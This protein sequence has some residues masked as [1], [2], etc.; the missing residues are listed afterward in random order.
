MKA[1]ADFFR[2]RAGISPQRGSEQSTY[3][4]HPAPGGTPNV[5]SSWGTLP[6]EQIGGSSSSHAPPPGSSMGALGPGAGDVYSSG[7]PTSS[8]VGIGPP[9]GAGQQAPPFG[10]S[11]GMPVQQGAHLDVAPQPTAEPMNGFASFERTGVGGGGSLG[12]PDRRGMDASNTGPSGQQPV[13]DSAYYA[14]FNQTAPQSGGGARMMDFQAQSSP[15]LSKE[16]AGSDAISSSHDGKVP[17]EAEVDRI[18]ADLPDSEIDGVTLLSTIEQAV[19]NSLEQGN[20]DRVEKLSAMSHRLSNAMKSATERAVSAFDQGSQVAAAAATGD[21]M[22]EAF[23]GGQPPGAPS[24]PLT[25]GDELAFAD[26]KA[27]KSRKK[28]PKKKKKKRG[29]SV[30]STAEAF[31]ND[32]PQPTGASEPPPAAAPEPSSSEFP[33]NFFDIA[34]DAGTIGEPQPEEENRFPGPGSSKAMSTKSKSDSD[35]GGGGGAVTSDMEFQV[36]DEKGS[37]R[38]VNTEVGGDGAAQADPNNFR[39]CSSGSEN[40]FA[41]HR[42]ERGRHE[43]NFSLRGVGRGA[44]N[45]SKG[46]TEA[47]DDADEKTIANLIDRMMDG[48]T[49]AVRMPVPAPRGAFG[50]KLSSKGDAAIAGSAGVGTVPPSADVESAAAPSDAGSGAKS[51]PFDAGVQSATGQAGQTIVDPAVNESRASSLAGPAATNTTPGSALT[52]GELGAS[53]GAATS[54]AAAL[55]AALLSKSGSSG[56][57]A[58][59]GGKKPLD[60]QRANG[61]QASPETPS[62]VRSFDL[63]WHPHE[64][65]KLEERERR[66]KQQ[67]RET[68]EKLQQQTKNVQIL[69]TQLQQSSQHLAAVKQENQRRETQMSNQLQRLEKSVVHLRDEHDALKTEHERL[70]ARCEEREDVLSQ[71]RERLF[72]EKDRVANM[73]DEVEEKRSLFQ[74]LHTRVA[75]VKREK[76]TAERELHD[77]YRILEATNATVVGSQIRITTKATDPDHGK[78]D[79]AKCGF[80]DPLGALRIADASDELA[81]A[82]VTGQERDTANRLQ[83]RLVRSASFSPVVVAISPEGQLSSS[84]WDKK[85]EEFFRNLCISTSGPVYE[86]DTVILSAYLQG[87]RISFALWNKN[88]VSAVVEVQVGVVATPQ[89]QTLTQVN[90]RVSGEGA[91]ERLALAPPWKYTEPVAVNVPRPQSRVPGLA[92][93]S[94]D[95]HAPRCTG[96]REVLPQK[97]ERLEVILSPSD[98]YVGA[99]AASSSSGTWKTSDI[100]GP[101]AAFLVFSYGTFDNQRVAA[102]LRLP[103]SRLKLQPLKYTAHAFHKRWST[104]EF[105]ENE[106][107]FVAKARTQFSLDATSNGWLY[108]LKCCELRGELKAIALG[109]TADTEHLQAQRRLDLVGVVPR[110]TASPEVFVRA[111]LFADE[112]ESPTTISTT[113]SSRQMK[114][115]CLVRSTSSAI[116]QSVKDMLINV[117]AAGGD[118]DP[119]LAEEHKKTLNLIRPGVAAAQDASEFSSS[120][121]ATSSQQD[122]VAVG[123]ESAAVGTKP[124]LLF[125]ADTV[126]ALREAF[127]LKA[128]PTLDALCRGELLSSGSRNKNLAEEQEN[129]VESSDP[130]FSATALSQAQ[131]RRITGRNDVPSGLLQR[132]KN[133]ERDYV[134]E[135]LVAGG[136]R[137]TEAT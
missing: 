77:L 79:R 117:L 126:D 129:A 109:D 70:I 25:S 28:S 29:A 32:T 3:V 76:T 56:P 23:T 98:F 42:R 87:E 132:I 111:E 54:A 40:M 12:P 13:G 128:T 136:N 4:P 8:I 53:S 39:S 125:Q 112:T 38:G 71:T 103:L 24:A 49:A 72:A 47:E 14:A 90:A 120:R 95:T 73:M 22:L 31:D 96:V 9:S 5:A 26:P 110:A 65:L 63:R 118:A 27:S 58:A 35:P 10:A 11:M 83:L 68:T 43:G 122:A 78:D 102:T 45:H 61:I 6:N 113:A 137:S 62:S 30:D 41:W 116:S 7:G 134:L 50:E 93:L 131:R 81:R 17:T 1:A 36:P 121:A 52:P 85:V 60:L 94:G 80:S 59:S 124:T 100:S 106:A 86:D 88:D 130:L 89:A 57:F 21:E 67:L 119:T 74:S 133:R 15:V 99:A 66:Y 55:A 2:R 69:C 108:F 91:A 33:T 82:D 37:G 16:P 75:E 123:E 114:V 20:Y 92:Q 19:L 104:L 84:G 18:I 101:T 34:S 44:Q 107:S 135:Q 127:S 48:V 64:L 97:T 105:A 115:R 51:S 46:T